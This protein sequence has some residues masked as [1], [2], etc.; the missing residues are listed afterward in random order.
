MTFPP[1]LQETYS[2]DDDVLSLVDCDLRAPDAAGGVNS[3]GTRC[4]TRKVAYIF[5]LHDDLAFSLSLSLSLSF[6]PFILLSLTHIL[7]LISPCL[8]FAVFSV[9]CSSSLLSSLFCDMS[10]RTH[11]VL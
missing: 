7:I 3:N 4:V 6:S 8:V 11:G 1:P 10:S 9:S 5:F 2:N